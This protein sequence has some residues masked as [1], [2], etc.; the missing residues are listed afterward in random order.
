MCG[1]AAEAL[2]R[3]VMVKLVKALV[4]LGFWNFLQTTFG[5]GGQWGVGGRRPGEFG[6]AGGVPA[7]A[8][9]RGR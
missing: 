9:W 5:I 2:A 4:H 6:V 1:S 8:T 7:L 3:I